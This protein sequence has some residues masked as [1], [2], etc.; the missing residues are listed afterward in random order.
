[1][2]AEKYE[3]MLLKIIDSNASGFIDVTQS[4]ADSDF[5]GDFGEFQVEGCLRIDD[6]LCDDCWTDYPN[7]GTNYSEVIGLLNYTYSNF[8]LQPRNSEDL[9]EE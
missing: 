5:G 8:K 7:I 1:M 6:G 4:N 2:Y 9:I 3:G